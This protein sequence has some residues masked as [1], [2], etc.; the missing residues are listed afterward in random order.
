MILVLIGAA[1]ITA[2]IG[3]LKDTA[4]I[5]AIVVLNGVVGFVQEYR[6]E[7]AMDALKRMTSPS[8]RVVRDGETMIVAAA[9]LDGDGAADL[10][11]IA[12]LYKS[13]VYQLGGFLG[14]P[15]GILNRVPTTDTYSMPQSQVEFYFPL[16]YEQMDLCLF[17]LNNALPPS[18][19]ASLAALATV[20]SGSPR[21]PHRACVNN[22]AEA[23]PAAAAQAARRS[24]G[25]SLA[26][27]VT[28][29]C[30]MWS[31]TSP[32]V[33]RVPRARPASRAPA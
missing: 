15:D 23:S 31:P 4:V 28:S 20:W 12:H 7:K 17:G 10:K 11:P 6:A 29:G 22:T 9:D 1:I 2:A 3:D 19:V 24:A 13:Q 25:S 21:A 26:R 32:R 18:E 33:D 30:V 14:V 5:M 16:P 27:R 8:S